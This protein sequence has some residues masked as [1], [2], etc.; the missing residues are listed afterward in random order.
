MANGTAVRSTIEDVQPDLQKDSAGY[1]KFIR[2]PYWHIRVSG[3]PI[4]S[5][6]FGAVRS[7]S[8]RPRNRRFGMGGSQP[9]ASCNGILTSR[10]CYANTVELDWYCVLTSVHIY[11]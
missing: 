5:G 2:D 1:H 11:R 8:A 3:R 6:H 7:W 4:V 10:L 9:L